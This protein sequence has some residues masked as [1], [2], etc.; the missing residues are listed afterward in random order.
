MKLLGY[1]L[2]TVGFLAGSVSAVQTAENSVEWTWFVPAFLLGVIGVALARVGAHR[3]ASHET[4]LTGDFDTVVSSIDRIV[5]KITL[6]DSEKANV[7]PY[8]VHERID[9]L[10]RDDLA[11][12]AEARESVGHLYT[13]SDYAEVMNSFAAGERYVNRVWSASIDGWIDELQEYLG[14]AKEQFLETQAKVQSL[15]G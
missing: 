7:D 15:Q 2:I 6:L 1:L 3:E 4:K 5:E 8:A 12:F 9:E 14:R 11:N 10:L 13:L